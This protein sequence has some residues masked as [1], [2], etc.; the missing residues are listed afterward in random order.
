[1]LASEVDEN[2]LYF[3]H[4]LCDD[5]D[6]STSMARAEAWVANARAALDV[7]AREKEA[8]TREAKEFTH[9]GFP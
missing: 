1:M 3:R 8:K 2:T 5:D 6:S 4:K 7:K 9:D